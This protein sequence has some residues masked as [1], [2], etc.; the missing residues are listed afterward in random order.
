MYDW[1]D[2]KVRLIS[3]GADPNESS[4][5]GVT[6]NGHDIFF[7]T[8]QRLV[9]QD[10]DAA[11][12]VY[13]ARVEGGLEAQNPPGSLLPCEG[14]ECRSGAS[15]P[16]PPLTSR[17]QAAARHVDC[18]R[19]SKTAKRLRAKAKRLK[20]KPAKAKARKRAKQLTRKAN[21]CRRQGK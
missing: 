20:K 4:F 1:R 12:D 13:D 3:T 10:T 15:S 21:Q 19:F 17:F 16:P 7:R 9:G 14:Q 6:A 2:G 8:S 18:T 5:A 11:S